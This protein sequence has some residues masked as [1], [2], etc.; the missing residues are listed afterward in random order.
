[1]A[2]AKPER[3]YTQAFGLTIGAHGITSFKA[4]AFDMG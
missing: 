4:G 2:D 1:M 3:I